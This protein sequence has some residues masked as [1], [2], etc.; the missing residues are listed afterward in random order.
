MRTSA[1]TSRSAGPLGLRRRRPDVRRRA[2]AGAQ[3]PLAHDSELDPRGLPLGEFTLPLVLNPNPDVV[4]TDMIELAVTSASSALLHDLRKDGR[5]PQLVGL[6]SGD[7]L[8]KEG[9]VGTICRVSVVHETHAVLFAERRYILKGDAFV[10]IPPRALLAPVELFEDFRPADVSEEASA[11]AA[12]AA[13][14]SA[15]DGCARLCSQVF[16]ISFEECSDE[17][18]AQWSARE[19]ITTTA[20][21]A[22][23]DDASAPPALL[24]EAERREAYSFRLT[25]NVFGTEGNDEEREEGIRRALETRSTVE[26]L[27]ACERFLRDSSAHLAAMRRMHG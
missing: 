2:G 20:A 16:P 11:A 26:R 25:R 27:R 22:D 15:Y 9:D 14:S 13:A 17:C 10:D 19:P 24:S 8:P 18:A 3:P 1:G 7:S 21:A 5:A 4:P 12:E 6:F 23:D